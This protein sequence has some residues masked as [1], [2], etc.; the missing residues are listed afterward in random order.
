MRQLAHFACWLMAGGNPP[1][2]E[3]VIESRS[4][5]TSALEKLVRDLVSSGHFNT[6]LYI[7]K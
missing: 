7:V 6:L 1:R 5:L 3:A 4:S 2:A